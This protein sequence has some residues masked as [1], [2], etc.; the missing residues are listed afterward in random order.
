MFSAPSGVPLPPMI[1]RMLSGG[2]GLST[3]AAPG[4]SL[5]AGAADGAAPTAAGEQHPAAASSS[6]PATPATEGVDSP[7]NN[8]SFEDRSG[9]NGL[10]HSSL[11]AEGANGLVGNAGQKPTAAPGMDLA[12]LGG[13]ELPALEPL[14]ALAGGGGG[15]CWS[16]EA[17][18][19]GAPGGLRLR[20]G[21]GLTARM[22]T[23]PHFPPLQAQGASRS[24]RRRRCS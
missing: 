11:G 22:A 21:A 13:G 19:G 4:S 12:A 18:W 7:S 2:K 3:D 20:V 15:A 23:E 17:G 9:A 8:S 14:R 10:A 24:T 6:Q 1:A 16:P 5:A